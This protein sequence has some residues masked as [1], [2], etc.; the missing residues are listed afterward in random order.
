MI[1]TVVLLNWNGWKDTIECLESV[2]RLDGPA[3]RVVVCDNASADGSWER[4]RQW[5]NGE[6]QAGAENPELRHLGRPHI[7]KPVEYRELTRAEAESQ[8]SIDD[9]RLVLIQN[10]E[11][12]GFAGGCNVGLRFALFD[13]HCQ[14]FWLLNNDTVVEPTALSAMV[15]LLQQRPEVGICGS[16]NI[17]YHSPKQVQAQGGKLYCRWTSRVHK[18]KAMTVDQL[19]SNPEAMDFINGASMLVTREFLE[20]VGLMEESYFLYFEELDWAMRAKGRF[21]LGYAAKSIIYH[22]EGACLGSSPNRNQRSLLADTYLARNRI[23]F[24][25]RFFP[26]AVPTVILSV[27]FAACYHLCRGDIA[28]ARAMLVNLLRGLVVKA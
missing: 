16:L 18:F 17:S 14:Y 7:E 4:I 13:T 3:F 5:A 20:G 21:E 11:N 6:L 26:W 22:K 23:L 27:T 28:R 1:A 12:L 24:T 10:G 19:D 8:T 25:R 9:H 15:R 2:F